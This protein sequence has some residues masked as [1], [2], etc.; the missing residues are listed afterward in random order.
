M[1]Y[2]EKSGLW[3]RVHTDCMLIV[4]ATFDMRT[5]LIAAGLSFC[6]ALPV[7]A[8]QTEWS[9]IWVASEGNKYSISE[10]K[11]KVVIKDGKLE[12]AME[13]TEGV[14]YKLS[15]VVA[16]SKINAK[17]T[18]VGS[19]YFID[20]LFSGSY[21]IKRWSGFADSKGRESITL[22]DGWNFIGL[23]REIR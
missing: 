12:A 17:F 2:P 21:T 14:E 10:G 20:S 13:S 18:V 7:H 3:L 5:I 8:D 16:K 1:S 4:R 23:S 6:L 15:G 11:A 22:T 9:F 19:G